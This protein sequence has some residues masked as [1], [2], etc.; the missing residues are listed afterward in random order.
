MSQVIITTVI[1]LI[2]EEQHTDMSLSVSNL[3]KCDWP[4]SI[5]NLEHDLTKIT[6]H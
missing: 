6:L 1:K 4:N 5:L 2:N 3:E